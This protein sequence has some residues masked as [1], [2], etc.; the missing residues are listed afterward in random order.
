MK[1]NNSSRRAFVGTLAAGAS[2]LL[3]IPGTT[4]AGSRDENTFSEADA[5]FKKV[6][7]SHRIVYDASLLFRSI[8]IATGTWDR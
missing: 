3:A 6:K 7:G 4:V 1:T 8:P 2:G 5:W